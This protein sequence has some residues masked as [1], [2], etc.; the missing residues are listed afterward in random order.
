MSLADD[1]RLLVEISSLYYEQGL[2]QEEIA[3]KVKI[4]RSLVSKY[5]VRAR[6]EG[7]VEIIIHDSYASPYRSLEEELQK[8]FVLKEVLCVD[9]ADRGIQNKLL[10]IAAAKYLSRVVK[11]GYTISVSAGTT[12]HEAAVN[13]PKQQ[14]PTLTFVPLVGGM[15]MEHIT[16]QSNRVCELFASRCGGKVTEL[17]APIT[18]DDKEAKRVLSSQSFIKK[19]FEEGQAADIALVGIGGIPIYSTLTDAYLSDQVNEDS[20]YSQEKIAGDICYNFIDHAGRL[21]DC[22]WNE[23]VI[24]IDLEK[25]K[26]VPLKIAVSGGR[27]KVEG[28]R[29]ALA[30]KLVDVLIT[31]EKTAR[32]LLEP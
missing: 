27:E 23:R 21:A 29:A 10:G 30:G 4:S 11:P 3:K 15:G 5:L 12:V 14:H 25:L 22:S 9:T 20:E 16:I 7:I 6:D 31:D 26:Q 13:F 19:V 28:I 1:K 18:V 32:R 8:K 2:K 24:A 17:H